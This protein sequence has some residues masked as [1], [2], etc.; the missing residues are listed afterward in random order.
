MG[1]AGTFAE[2][3][4]RLSQRRLAVFSS[5]EPDARLDGP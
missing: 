3:E 2:A 4:G 1:L 5:P